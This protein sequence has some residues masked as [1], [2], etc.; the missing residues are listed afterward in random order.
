M[1]LVHAS[2]LGSNT[3]DEL[4]LYSVEWRSCCHCC[5]AVCNHAPGFHSTYHSTY[6]NLA[7]FCRAVRRASVPARDRRR[8]VPHLPSLGKEGRHAE[9]WC[10]VWDGAATRRQTSVTVNTSACTPMTHIS[11]GY[12]SN[13]Y[14]NSVPLVYILYCVSLWKDI[15]VYWIV[16]CIL[17]W[18]RFVNTKQFWI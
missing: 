16:Q 5:T 8:R 12:A 9:S 13:P 6:S 17:G 18:Q 1:I 2:W 14:I 15:R 11:I 3:A 7:T 10:T 4:L